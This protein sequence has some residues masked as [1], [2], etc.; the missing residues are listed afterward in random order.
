MCVMNATNP[1]IILLPCVLSPSSLIGT[2]LP[3]SYS[4][5]STSY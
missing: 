3:I 1:E 2:T 5:L 4:K